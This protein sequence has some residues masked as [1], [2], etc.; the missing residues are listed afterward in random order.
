M[1]IYIMSSLFVNIDVEPSSTF[2]CVLHSLDY[3]VENL[4][5]SLLEVSNGGDDSCDSRDS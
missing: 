2:S 3:L 5:L 4:I 1:W